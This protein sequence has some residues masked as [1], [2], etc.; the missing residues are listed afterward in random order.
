[1]AAWEF[2]VYSRLFVQ[3]ESDGQVRR[4]MEPWGK[5]EG[6]LVAET[7]GVGGGGG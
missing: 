3:E 7:F 5:V 6:G 2:E 4:D 1:M